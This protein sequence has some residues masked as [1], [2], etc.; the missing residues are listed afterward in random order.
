MR[1]VIKITT[2]SM[3]VLSL[4]LHWALFQTVAWTGMMINYSHN[5]SFKE[6]VARTF[7]GKHPCPVCKAIQ[8]GRA[9][10]Q[11]RAPQQINSDSNL[12]F[13]VVWQSA[14]FIFASRHEPVP[15]RDSRAPTRYEAPPKP[16]PR[17]VADIGL[18]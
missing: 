17:L 6:A 14:E 8:K 11:K 9:E 1:W 18:V 5:S 2:V 16:H 12:D 4:G 7:D 3:F 10:E 13:A 15:A